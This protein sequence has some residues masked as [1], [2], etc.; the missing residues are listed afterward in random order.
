MW[1]PYEE[2]RLRRTI[3][4][5]MRHQL[6]MWRVGGVV[7]VLLGLFMLMLDSTDSIG[8]VFTGIGLAFVF[9]VGRATVAW[10]LRMQAGAVKD[11]CQMA[12][13]DEWLTV[14]NSLVESR[15]R[16]AAFGRVIETPEVWYIMF[17]KLQA[18]AVPKELMTDEQRATFTAFVNG[19]Q[20]TTR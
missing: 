6:N 2:E 16:W 17:G 12:I 20:P 15:I 18:V 1:V 13:S 19:L 4:F 5:V 14:A 11:G 8:Y 10:T 9:V 7:I 3:R